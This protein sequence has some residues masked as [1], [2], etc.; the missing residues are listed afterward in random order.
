MEEQVLKILKKTF[1]L[2]DFRKGQKEIINSILENQDVLAVLPTGGGKSL[3]YQ[4]PAVFKQNLTIVISP[5]IALMKDQV[6]SLNEKNIPAGCLYSGQGDEEKRKIFQDIQSKSLYIL[7]LS[8]ERVQKPG[9]QNWIIQKN[10]S[11]FAI[12][13]AHCVSQWG[14]D[15]RAEYSQL[16]ILR[17][18]KPQTPILALTASATPL[19]L[20]DILKQLDIRGAQKKVHG[21]YRPNLFYQVAACEN[22]EVKFKYLVSAIEKFSDGKII[23]YCGTR[24]I[25]E[26]LSESLKKYFSNVD[27][28]HAGMAT[29]SRNE[30]QRKYVHDE[31]RILIATNAF[32]MGIDQ[33][34][35]RLVVH[36]QIPANIDSLYQEM[37]R[38]GRDGDDSTC[39]LLYAKKDKGLQSY[40]IQNADVDE[41]FKS[42]KWKNLDAL[43]QYSEGSECRHAEILTYFRDSQRI[44]SCGH[45]DNCIP[46]SKRAIKL[47]TKWEDLQGNQNLSVQVKTK[48]KKTSYNS[49]V[50]LLSE[51]QEY[52][53][54]QLREWRKNKAKEL[55]VPA[56]IVFGDQT[57]R[58]IAVKLP[59]SKEDLLRIK[60]I[61]ESKIASFSEDILRITASFS[62]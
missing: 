1:N 23:V 5:L 37:G 39:L 41:E 62:E 20:F 25:T 30:I 54:E 32:G 43:I 24:K 14:H 9:F 10:V 50:E 29:E 2:Q 11:L 52:L 31:I 8:P 35:V 21:F 48:K 16:K 22:E 34:N 18:L 53:F 58:L 15:F 17:K 60:G 6:R 3:C 61:G 44:E 7:Y 36:Y 47:N 13:E 46:D 56:F 59:Q 57:L 42:N 40:F 19:V 28:Y 27:Y 38:A 26:E 4:L 55:D 49:P 12:D 33:P 45:C 51:Q